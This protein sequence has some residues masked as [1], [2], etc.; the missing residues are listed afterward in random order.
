MAIRIEDTQH[1]TVEF[2]GRPWVVGKVPHN[3]RVTL[4]RQHIA[5][6][7]ELGSIVGDLVDVIRS[8]SYLAQWRNIA[9]NNSSIYDQLDSNASPYRCKTL[10]SYIVGLRDYTPKSIH[11][12][13]VQAIVKNIQGF[14]VMWP[15]DF[16]SAEDTS[17]SAAMK[18]MVA[19]EL[20]V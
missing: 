6:N 13:L 14:L 11:D 12:P 2:A 9:G 3:M 16:L 8:D 7:H 1:L 4:M 19:T 5:W 15:L 18:L 20:W 17:P 10:V